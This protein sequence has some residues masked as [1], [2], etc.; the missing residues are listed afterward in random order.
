VAAPADLSV[1]PA[2]STPRPSVHGLQSALVVGPA[3]EEIYVDK[4][5]RVKVQFY[6]DREGS[7]NERSSCWVRVASGWAGKNWGQ[8]HLPRIG[9]EVLV[10]F[11][12]GDPDRPVVIGSVYNAD[13]MPPYTLPG[14]K[15]RSG[16]KSRSSMGGGPGTFNEI[17]F[18]DKQGAEQFYVHAQKDLATIVQNDESREIMNDRAT[19]VKNDDKHDVGNDLNTSVGN[20]AVLEAMTSITLKVGQNSIVV[21]QK[22]V[23]IKGIKVQIEGQAEASMKG[24]MLKLEGTGMSE[25]KAPMT[26]VKGD[27]ML[28][29]KGGLTM[30]N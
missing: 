15:T 22:G 24:A 9:Q 12:E 13:H 6:W 10:E 3:G 28:V 1:R 18:E 27:G 2:R 21:D 7:K 17:R 5:G 14:N 19:E 25:L 20:E 8:V 26:T 30:I 16:V 11:V 23:T 29:V 4:Y